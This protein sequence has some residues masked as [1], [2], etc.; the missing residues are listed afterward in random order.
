MAIG[1]A[2]KAASIPQSVLNQIS[3]AQQAPSPN[4]A[5]SAAQEA[6]ETRAV[7]EREAAKGDAVAQRKLAAETV[8]E[9]HAAATVEGKGGALNV[10]A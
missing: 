10:A 1:S 9:G 3:A 4:V 2:E 6:Q 7:T 8:S 5:K